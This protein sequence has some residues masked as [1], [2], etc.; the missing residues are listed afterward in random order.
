MLRADNISIKPPPA[1]QAYAR[2][3]GRTGPGRIQSSRV[4]RLAAAGVAERRGGSPDLRSRWVG[5]PE[6]EV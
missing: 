1:V 2:A 6:A 5:Q 3:T 4:E